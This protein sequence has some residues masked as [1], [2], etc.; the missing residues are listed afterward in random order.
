MLEL[1]VI[2]RR[3]GHQPE[4]HLP[5]SKCSTMAGRPEQTSN[6]KSN[7]NFASI[8]S[9]YRHFLCW[10]HSEQLNKRSCKT[11]TSQAH[12]YF[13]WL[14]AHSCCSYVSHGLFMFWKFEAKYLRVLL[15]ILFFPSVRRV[16]KCTSHTSTGSAC[17]VAWHFM[18]CSQWWLPNRRWH[19]ARLCRCW[20]IACCRW[21]F[22]PA[23]MCS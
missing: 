8:P 22:C 17:L 9:I 16:G 23:S 20:A 21:S 1:F 6:Q 14:W 19:W 5:K 15:K 10:T 12:W 7:T 13:A 4:S 2:I 11:P 18:P 3:A